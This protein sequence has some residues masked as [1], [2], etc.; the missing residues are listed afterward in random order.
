MIVCV[1]VYIFTAWRHKLR[2]YIHTYISLIGL[3]RMV[4][5][6]PFTISLKNKNEDS[7]SYLQYSK[8]LKYKT[9][10]KTYMY[11]AS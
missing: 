3:P 1:L 11:I 2:T 4:F 6:N 8:R 9:R 7:K 5:K 10:E